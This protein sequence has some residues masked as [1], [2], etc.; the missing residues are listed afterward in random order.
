MIRGKIRP[1]MVYLF[2]VVILAGLAACSSTRSG[3]RKKPS[4][5]NCDCPRWSMNL[6]ITPETFIYHG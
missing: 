2:L 3:Y 4:R 1:V 6:Q 5:R